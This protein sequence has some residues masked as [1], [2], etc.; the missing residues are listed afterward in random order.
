LILDPASDTL[1]V[2]QDNKFEARFINHDSL[3]TVGFHFGPLKFKKQY[4]ELQDTLDIVEKINNQYFVHIHPKQLGI[5]Q[6][7]GLYFYE[8][9]LNADT[10]AYGHVFVYNKTF[11]VK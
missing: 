9:K 8:K 5:Y 11:H 6:L 7:T 2:N 4:V 1:L 10:I 3:T